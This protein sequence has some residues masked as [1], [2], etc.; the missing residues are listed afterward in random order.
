ML[1][2]VSSFVSNYSYVKLQTKSA[3][4]LNLSVLNHVSKL[5]ILYFKD[6]DT[7]YLNQ[8]INSDSNTLVSFILNNILN[9]IIKALT[10]IFLFYVSFKI[11]RKI[12]IISMPLIPL[13]LVIIK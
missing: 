7:T 5:P 11:N 13:Y 12:T 1:G 2:I 10:L 4:D 8:R 3:I 6:I 9:I